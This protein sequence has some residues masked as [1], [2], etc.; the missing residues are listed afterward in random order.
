[1]IPVFYVVCTLAIG[2]MITSIIDFVFDMPNAR[3]FTELP[4]HM[5]I[6]IICIINSWYLVGVLF[7]TIIQVMYVM[8]LQKI[9]V[10][11]FGDF[12]TSNLWYVIA[13]LFAEIVSLIFHAIIISALHVNFYVR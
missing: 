13:V 6:I 12:G 3:E 10:R 1:M 2:F 8:N 11:D 5:L 9:K 4:I 7:G